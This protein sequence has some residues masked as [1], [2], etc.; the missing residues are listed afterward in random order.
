MSGPQK[1]ICLATCCLWPTQS[2]RPDKLK[3]RFRDSCF[4]TDRVMVAPVDLLQPRKSL[5]VANWL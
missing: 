5:E 2:A 4:A 3:M 1:T